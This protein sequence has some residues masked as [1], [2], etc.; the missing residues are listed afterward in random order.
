MNNKTSLIQPEQ[1]E[2][3]I[4]F[5]RGQRVMLDRDLRSSKDRCPQG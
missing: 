1:I 3:I 4:L 2:R 5:I